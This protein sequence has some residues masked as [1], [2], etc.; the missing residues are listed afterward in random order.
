MAKDVAELLKP[1]SEEEPSGPDLAYDPERQ[2]LEEAFESSV[3]IDTS[4]GAA[5]SSDVDWRKLARQIEDQSARTKDIWLAVYLCRAGARL[6]DLEVVEEGAQFLAGLMET[7]WETVHPQLEEYGFQGR[8]GPCESLTRIGEF[9]G[10]LQRATLL[11]HPRLGQFST[12]DFERFRANAE[13][14]DGYGL[15][16][17]ALEDTPDERL[18]EIVAR[19]DRIEDGLKRADAVLTN[20][21]EGDTGVNFR[22]TYEVL[23]SMRRG[24]SAFRNAAGDVAVET[25]T[26]ADAGD[27]GPAAPSAASGSRIA[28]RVESREDVIKALDAICDYY[29]REEPGSP[30]PHVL[31][32]A[33]DWVK[34]DFLAILEDIVPSAVDDARRLLTTQRS[35]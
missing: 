23:A 31:T 24:V 19:V 25:E 33:R 2:M 30:V 10:P 8:K 27:D 28:G 35:S 26:A 29:R 13:A 5:A 32:R 34:L 22:P 1:I 21:A 18:A 11:A 12:L 9:L 15:F 14:E 4:G 7:F 3:S 20:N 17:A 16:R 6:G